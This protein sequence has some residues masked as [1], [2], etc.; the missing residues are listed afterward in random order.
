MN[1]KYIV[2]SGSLSGLG[3]GTTVACLG[4]VI[5]Q[6]TDLNI[7][8]MKIDPYLNINT[9]MMNPYEHGEVFVL[10]DGGQVD[11]DFGTYE[12]FLNKNF[13]QENSIT[14]GQIYLKLINDER[15]GK[16]SGKTVQII[17]HFTNEVLRRIEN[18]SQKADLVIIE[19][20]GTIGDYESIGFIEAL[21]QLRV[22]V[23]PENFCSIHVSHLPNLCEL[24]TK[25]TQQ[26]VRTLRELGYQA[27][28]IVCRSESEIPMDVK[29][30]ISDTCGV[31]ISNVIDMHNQPDIFNIPNILVQQEF[32]QN[33]LNHFD[34]HGNFTNIS[35]LR[36][37]GWNSGAQTRTVCVVGK[38]T[39][40]NDAYLSLKH[41][42]IFAGWKNG[43][44]V[45]INWVN[46]EDLEN[47]PQH[48]QEA[49][50]IIIPGGF[51]VRGVQG[52]IMAAKYARENKVPFLGICFGMQI[53]VIEYF[54]N[55]M[56]LN[57]NSIEIDPNTKFPV[58]VENLKNELIIGSQEISL[59]KDSLVAEI[60][61]N[62][63]ISERKRHRYIFNKYYEHLTGMKITGSSCNSDVIDVVE[64]PGQF[65]IGVQ[66]HPEF[67][68]RPE[69]GHPLFTAL[70][71]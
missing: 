14:S 50:A 53:A 29:Q 16:Y 27:D 2:V 13:S 61:N 24:K 6:A 55:V 18:V 69:T 51:G 33:V 7:E 45:N 4:R 23:K 17:P 63:T 8:I 26:S 48:L 66:F 37:S 19:L 15:S 67:N 64:I 11:L 43:I 46:S 36:P 71:K 10:N 58:F 12:R 31:S 52:K 49:S 56:D 32:P 54:Q 35:G 40:L 42:I 25:T 70:L 22:K 62:S 5:Q 60:Y 20:G 41:S 3:K 38:Y 34:M 28:F 65:Y 9:E 21:R 68:S 1:T 30:K 59:E 47:L 39:Q 44:N 57:A